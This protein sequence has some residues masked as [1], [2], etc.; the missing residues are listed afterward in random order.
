MSSAGSLDCSYCGYSARIQQNEER[1]AEIYEA[2]KQN[3]IEGTDIHSKIDSTQVKMQESGGSQGAPNL[4]KAIMQAAQ[5]GQLRG[6]HGRLGDLGTVDDMYDVAAC[7]AASGTLDNIVVDNAEAAQAV[8]EFCKQRRLGRVTC[9]ILDKIRE[10]KPTGDPPE[11]TRRLI[12]LIKP[13][14]RKFRP[15]FYFAVRETLVAKDLNQAQRVGH[16]ETTGGRRYRVVSLD[17]KLVETSGV[18]SAGGRT[19]KGLFGA[20]RGKDPEAGS[21]QRLE[22]QVARLKQ[23]MDELKAT[24]E[25]LTNERSDL[26]DMNRQMKATLADHEQREQQP[27][28]LDAVKIS[29]QQFDRQLEAIV[30][31]ELSDDEKKKVAMLDE[32][33]EDKQGELNEIQAGV[34]ELLEAIKLLKDKILR[35]EGDKTRAQKRKMEE[36]K[37]SLEERRNHKRRMALNIRKARENAEKALEK[38]EQLRKD[39]ET[40]EKEEEKRRPESE[41]LQEIA[42]GLFEDH[43]QLLEQRKE[44]EKVVEELKEKVKQ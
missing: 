44:Q 14:E 18:M 5:S 28:N 3:G 4:R 26:Q 40:L 22:Q 6:V 13:N 8:V 2:L 11:D 10:K 15:A 1:I 31:P 36:L 27:V 42:L 29:I 17:G 37:K 34:A 25:K 39:I 19:A 7:T 24:R 33:I 12:D 20:Q 32:K 21:Y 43:N 35:S 16:G 30:C 9:I 38:A 41:K 23:K